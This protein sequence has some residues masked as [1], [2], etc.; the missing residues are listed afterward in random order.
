MKASW[1]FYD[2]SGQLLAIVFT[3]GVAFYL[4]MTLVNDGNAIRVKE[5]KPY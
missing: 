4:Y 1:E 5:N 2:A 3:A